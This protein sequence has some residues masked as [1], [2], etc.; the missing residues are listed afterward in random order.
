[1]YLACMGAR[2]RQHIMRVLVTFPLFTLYLQLASASTHCMLAGEGMIPII[3]RYDYLK[4]TEHRTKKSHFNIRHTAIYLYL[5]ILNKIGLPSKVRN[6]GLDVFKRNHLAK[7]HCQYGWRPW[8]DF[9]SGSSG[10]TVVI[11]CIRYSIQTILELTCLGELESRASKT[12]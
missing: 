11:Y 8:P 6:I 4:S 9:P 12:L 1:M 10:C 2:L 7:V 5:I 3:E